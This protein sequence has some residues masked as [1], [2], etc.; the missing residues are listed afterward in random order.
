V[1]IHRIIGVLNEPEEPAPDSNDATPAGALE[2]VAV[3]NASFRYRPDGPL[4]LDQISVTIPG[5]STV[6][7]VGPSGSGKSTL[8]AV[9]ARLYDLEVGHGSVQLDGAD[10]RSYSAARLRQRVT[11]VPQQSALFEGTIRSNLT[12]A[13]PD[14]SADAVWTVLKAV[15]LAGL[16]ERLP[17]G[18]ETPV[19]ERGVTL[20]GGQRQRLA[21]ARAVLANPPVLL[22]DDCTSALDPETESRVWINLERMSARQTRIVVSHKPSSVRRADWVI[23][24]DRGRVTEQGMPEVLSAGSWRIADAAILEE[25]WQA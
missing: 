4:V 18:L 14:A 3:R 13:A 11:L 8:L 24:L 20:S 9:L 12:Y 5:G 17:Q 2:G 6:A 10:L 22:L 25:K 1:A 15:E 23:V 19:G 21:L 7:L 16:V